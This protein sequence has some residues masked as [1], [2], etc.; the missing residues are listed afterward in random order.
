MSKDVGKERE[1]EAEVDEFI[2]PYV[3]MRDFSG[4]ILMA[5]DGEILVKRAYGMAN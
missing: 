3:E 5:G 1:I 2:K 4:A